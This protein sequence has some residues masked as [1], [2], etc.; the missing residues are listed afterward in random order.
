MEL[1]FGK[2]KWEMWWDPLEDFLEKTR[3]S[4][5]DATEIYIPALSEKPEQIAAL[6]DRYGLKLIAQ[7]VSEGK[8]PAEHLQTIEERVPL[9]VDCCPISISC[10]V[11]RDIFSFDD[12]LKIFESVIQLSRKYEIDINIETHRGRPTYSAVETVKYLSALPDMCL[13]A[14]FSHWMVVHESNL[15]DQEENLQLAIERSSHIHARVGYEEGPQINDPEAP[16]WRQH[17]ARHIQIWQSILDSRKA[18]KAP[19]LTIVP[20]FGPVPYMQTLPFTKMPVADVW[21]V[22]VKMKERLQR[23]LNL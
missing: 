13:T 5:F 21:E 19:F 3:T 11:G 14:D 12:N 2:S 16:E 23:E 1:K 6:H 17:V 15:E 4:G 9:A 20:E 18:A 10:H 8:T 7:I 22:N